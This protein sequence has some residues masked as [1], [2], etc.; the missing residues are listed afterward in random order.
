M[1]LGWSPG[2][3]GRSEVLKGEKQSKTHETHRVQLL[4]SSVPFKAMLF[5]RPANDFLL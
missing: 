4:M 2:S 1:R 3:L 5:W